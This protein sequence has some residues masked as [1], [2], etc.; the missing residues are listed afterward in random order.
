MVVDAGW[1]HASPSAVNCWLLGVAG[2][3]PPDAELR[4][5]HRVLS[6]PNEATLTASLSALAQFPAAVELTAPVALGCDDCDESC[7]RSLVLPAACSTGFSRGSWACSQCG[8]PLDAGA[9]FCMECGAA[10]YHP[11]SACCVEVLLPVTDHSEAAAP[12]HAA[13]LPHHAAAPL[14]HVAVRELPFDDGGIGHCVWPASIALAIWLHRHADVIRGQRVLELGSGVG[15]AGLAC[16]IAGAQSVHLPDRDAEPPSPWIGGVA[17]ASDGAAPIRLRLLE[18]L[19]GNAAA[20]ERAGVTAV[21]ALDWETVASDRY[22]PP[23]TYPVVIG[24]DIVYYEQT[25]HALA[26]SVTKLTA[27]GGLALLLSKRTRRPGLHTTLAHLREV[28][29]VEVEELVLYD[30]AEGQQTDV[31]LATFHKGTSRRGEDECGGEQ[32]SER[33]GEQASE[34]TG[35][36]LGEAAL[37]LR[38]GWSTPASLAVDV[39]VQRPWKLAATCPTSG[40]HSAPACPVP[41]V[42]AHAALAA[43][44]WLTPSPASANGFDEALRLCPLERVSCVSSYDATPGRFVEPWEYEGTREDAV[45]AV[46]RVASRLGGE[47]QRDDSSDEGTAL[48]VRFAATADAA[49]FWFPSDD[50][51]VQFRSERTDGSLWDGAANKLRIDQMRKSLG[52]APAPMVRNRYYRPGELRADGTIRLEE[53]RPYKRADGRFYGDQ[54]GGESGGRLTSVGSPEALRRLLF[55]F[56]RLGGRTSPA[57]A[58]YDDVNDLATRQESVEQKLYGR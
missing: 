8:E 12:G 45:R 25:S 40:G 51:L 39:A 52:Y 48:R 43:C 20:N 58:L 9:S 28:G 14:R 10:V 27:A 13:T 6:A 31:V 54:G 32:V 55:P 29:S 26:A 5:C 56:S 37:R 46:A 42:V 21:H 50:F 24:S 17:A 44:C 18:N 49:I 35:N 38:G 47:V 22:T 4:L 15:L 3:P 33:G 16:G 2:I 11:A 19:K 1:H 34:A 53:E 23:R 41:M 36:G 7:W 57:Q 30:M